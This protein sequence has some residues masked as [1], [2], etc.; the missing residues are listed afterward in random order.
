[1]RLMSQVPVLEVTKALALPRAQTA[2]SGRPRQ[3]AQE[4]PHRNEVRLDRRPVEAALRP[5]PWGLISCDRP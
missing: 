1:M 5:R 3:T 2:R 4:S